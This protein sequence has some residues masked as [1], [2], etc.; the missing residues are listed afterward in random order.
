M[1][2]KLQTKRPATLCAVLAL[3]V[4]FVQADTLLLDFGPTPPT[5]ANLTNSPFHAVTGS[6]LSAWNILGT[7]DS[8]D[9][10]WG[11]G[12]QA[13][14]VSINLGVSP[15]NDIINFDNQPSTSNALG[16]ADYV[17][18]SVFDGDSVGTDGLFSGST[19]QQN[20]I[21][22][23]IG[24]LPLDTYFVNIVGINTNI[25]SDVFNVANRVR[26]NIGAFATTD[27][28]TLD[29]EGLDFT[30]VANT[31]YDTWSEGGNYARFAVTLTEDNPY[32]TIFTVSDV[33]SEGRGFLNT[34]TVTTI[35]EPSTLLLVLG[36]GLLGLCTFRKRMRS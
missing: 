7:A 9:L 18:G 1:K 32:L 31:V 30:S 3:M 20:V 27:V 5:G 29:I 16:M 8:S 12:T 17:E 34:V 22:L 6:S 26:M 10:V 19:G 15:G 36:F 13:T 2:T 14:D 23:K 25:D 24:G 28:G 33:A 11:D 21:G 4:S 35:P